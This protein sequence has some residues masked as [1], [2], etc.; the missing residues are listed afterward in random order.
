MLEARLHWV[1]QNVNDQAPI[2][3]TPLTLLQG[4]VCDLISTVG[5]YFKYFLLKKKKAVCGE[6]FVPVQK[7]PAIMMY[8]FRN[9][10]FSS[11]LACF[12]VN[13]IRGALD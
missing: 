6:Q 10:H 5:N 8:N 13:V 1:F 12:I 2:L 11:L 9:K 4:D 3:R 7:V